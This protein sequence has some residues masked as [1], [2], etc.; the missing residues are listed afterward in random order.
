MKKLLVIV[1][2]GVNLSCFA[3]CQD[4]NDADLQKKVKA[5]AMAYVSYTTARDMFFKGFVLGQLSKTDHY[6]SMVSVLEDTLLSLVWYKIASYALKD[7]PTEATET[8]IAA[9]VAGALRAF[10]LPRVNVM[11]G[12]FMCLGR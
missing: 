6:W 9:A 12:G 3:S 8:E 1:L 10:F 11:S 5:A 7:N 4:I 2:L